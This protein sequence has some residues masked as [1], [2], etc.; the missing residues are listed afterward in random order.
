MPRYS[1]I[2]A[3]QQEAKRRKEN[4]LISSFQENH[5]LSDTYSYSG[6]DILCLVYI[7]NYSVDFLPVEGYIQIEDKLQ[8]LTVSSARSVSPVRR[9]GETTPLSYA[10]GSRTI[11]GSMVFTTGLRDAFVDAMVRCGKANGIEPRREPTLFI[12]QMPKFSMILQASNE[13][14]GVSTAVLLNITLTNF[15]TTFSID[16]I[17]TES[18]FTYVAEQYFPLSKVYAGDFKLSKEKSVSTVTS[19]EV[20]AAIRKQG[21]DALSAELE[22]VAPMD[23]RGPYELLGDDG[24]L[25][26]RVS[27]SSAGLVETRSYMGS[28]VPFD[29]FFPDDHMASMH[30]DL[31]MHPEKNLVGGLQDPF[32]HGRKKSVRNR[33]AEKRRQMNKMFR[34]VVSKY[35]NDYMDYTELPPLP[36]H[37]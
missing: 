14:G 28:Q 18:T 27:R 8:T 9:L 34:P 33:M 13:L 15:G 30:E 35:N 16:D 3:Q 21:S 2:Q 24:R 12:D 7:P 4:G 31:I 36:W 25:A 19:N 29:M 32:F 20:A 22:I 11:A 1:Y 6:S 37:H 23:S 26:G 17:Y 5:A 10:R